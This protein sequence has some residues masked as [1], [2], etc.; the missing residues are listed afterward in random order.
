MTPITDNLIDVLNEQIQCAEAMLNALGRENEALIDGDADRLNAASAD[1]ARLVER[2]DSLEAERRDL[3]AAIEAT[4]GAE[5]PDEDPS[6]APKWHALLELITE[7]KQRN[8]RNGALVKTRSDQ[9]RTA[10]KVL[11]GGDPDVYD[12]SGLKPYSRTARQ[13]GSA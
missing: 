9:V 7:C 11:R 12:P 4:M 5:Q 2:L 3:T 8:Q 10:L 1:K 6:V 13:L